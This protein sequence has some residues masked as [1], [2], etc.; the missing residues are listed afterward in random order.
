MQN[1]RSLS[2]WKTAIVQLAKSRLINHSNISPFIHTYIHIH[3]VSSV[4]LEN[5]ALYTLA[6]YLHYFF[7]QFFPWF[8]YAFSHSWLLVQLLLHIHICVCIKLKFIYYFMSMSILPVYK[9]VHICAWCPKGQNGLLHSS[10]TGITK[11][12][13]PSLVY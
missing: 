11:S 9:Y 1:Y 12:S 6:K 3:C 8:L 10:E 13:E 4:T 5:S 7:P 2:C